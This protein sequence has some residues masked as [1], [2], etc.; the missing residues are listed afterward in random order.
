MKSPFRV[1][2]DIGGVII[3]KVNDESDTSFFGDNFLETTAVPGSFEGISRLID[4]HAEVFL[5]SK[6]GEKVQERTLQ[7]LNYHGF[8]N[9]TGVDPENAHFCKQRH[10]K[11]GICEKLGLTHFADDRLEVLSYL[12]E[13]VPNLYLINGE[14]REI[15]RFGHV[16]DRVVQVATWPVLVDR[17]LATQPPVVLPAVSR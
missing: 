6:C 11:A 5:V 8:F 16:L 9:Q 2:I 1:G 7:W 12:L 13:I 15:R 17:I 10:E 14:D 3:G 4:A